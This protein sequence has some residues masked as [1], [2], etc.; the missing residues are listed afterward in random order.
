MKILW[1]TLQG[2]RMLYKGPFFLDF[3][4][5]CVESHRMQNLLFLT[6]GLKLAVIQKLILHYKGQ[7]FIGNMELLCLIPLHGKV[8]VH[9]W[10]A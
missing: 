10:V 9:W 1:G 7:S 8:T 3:G 5:N 6:N 2:F 4:N